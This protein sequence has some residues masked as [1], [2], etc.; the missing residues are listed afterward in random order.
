MGQL[1]KI[2]TSSAGLLLWAVLAVQSADAQK[3]YPAIEDAWDATDYRA[4]VQRVQKDGLELP[5]LAGSDTKPVFER[6][7]N[8]DNIPLRMGKNK[9]LAI[10]IRFQRLEPLLS[11]LHKLIVLYSN[12]MQKGKP[13]AAELARLM[14]YEAKA[15][16]TLLELSESFLSS[17]PKDRRYQAIAAEHD[18]MKSSAREIYFGL[19]QN[20]ADARVYSKS[21]RLKMIGGA[22]ADLPSYHP[23][24]SDQDKQNLT[25]KLG[26][27]I[28][29]ATDQEL[30]KA[31]TELRDAIVHGRIPT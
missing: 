18:K 6:M 12:E 30:K 24:F 22:Q 21:D 17:L 23:I 20:I 3:R 14:V 29:T 1:F 7:V 25:Q 28:S 9:D 27:Q 5:T 2:L 8:A 16:G 15:A 4:L 10:T 19:V 11:P 26:Q 31:L 13:Y